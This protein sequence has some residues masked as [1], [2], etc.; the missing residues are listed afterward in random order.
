M[1]R[2]RDVDPQDS[3]SS[4]SGGGPGDVLPVQVDGD[5]ETPSRLYL[6]S[7]PARGMVRVREWAS[8]T[9]WTGEAAERE[10]RADELYATFERAH[11][12]RLRLSE[13]LYR[14]RH[15]LAGSPPE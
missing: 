10:V 14:I 13:D 7:R 1:S 3:S 9:G 4:S 15:W 6:I 2:G 11:A 8:E 5:R 12:R